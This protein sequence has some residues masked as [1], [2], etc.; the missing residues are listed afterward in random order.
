MNPFNIFEK[1]YCINLDS[2][3]DRW[4]SA[5]KEFA[6]LNILGYVNR[7]P[8]VVYTGTS[9]RH[10]NA[11]LGNHLAHANCLIDVKKRGLDSCL[12]FEDDI[13]FFEDA[14][15]NL[16]QAVIEL[17]TDWDMFYLGV[18]MDVYTAYQISDHIAK[19]SGGFATHAYAVRRK[20]FDKLIEVNLNLSISHNDVVYANEIIPNNNCYIPIPLVAG[21]RM[22][23]SDIEGRV[24]DYNGMFKQRFKDKLVTK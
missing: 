10:I 15:E 16:T 9:D 1:I 7:E 11:C 2:R 21:Q 8:G 3:P 20:L 19:L 18:N 4:D 5:L 13:E 22:S 23:F 24:T 17:P 12:I 6:K 14:Y